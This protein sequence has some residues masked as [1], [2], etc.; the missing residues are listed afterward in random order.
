MKTPWPFLLAFALIFYVTGAAFVES[1]VN[2]PSWRLI[3]PHEF[4]AY[5]HFITPRI[6][7]YMVVPSLLTSVF[8]VLMLWWRPVEVPRWSVWLA[9]GLQTTIW[10]SSG[11]IQ[12]PMQVEFSSTGFS[13]PR[14][15]SL[16]FSNFWL[17]RI[18]GVLCAMLF[19][20][21]MRRVVSTSL[22][23]R[24]LATSM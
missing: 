24:A 3:G 23:D 16:I 22:R 4:V 20:W 21:M 1:F 10:V 5:H 13:E 15:S 18:P 11:V 2:Y 19:V 6:V 17:R 9:I 12:I 7:G 14:L 8:T